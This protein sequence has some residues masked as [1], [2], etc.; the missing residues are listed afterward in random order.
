MSGVKSTKRTFVRPRDFSI[1]DHLGGAFGI[2]AGAGDH[3]IRLR[4]QGWATRIVRERF[5]H[6]SQKFTEGKDG[7]LVME[8]R[9]S[10]LE[11]I[12][13]WILSFGDQVEVLEPAELRETIAQLGRSISRRNAAAR[14]PS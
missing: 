6:E 3:R 5:W 14:F 1:K 13:R 8:L 7:T 2:F 9:L 4:F 11:E 10:G 12:Q